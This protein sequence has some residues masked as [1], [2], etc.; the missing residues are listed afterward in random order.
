MPWLPGAPLP[1]PAATRGAP[2]A[3]A[4]DAAVIGTPAQAKAAVAAEEAAARSGGR[5]RAQSKGRKRA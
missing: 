3:R 5:A 4:L 2:P 1:E